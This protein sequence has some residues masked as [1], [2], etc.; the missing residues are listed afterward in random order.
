MNYE[1]CDDLSDRN[2][3]E[4]SG[5]SS[6][7]ISVQTGHRAAQLAAFLTIVSCLRQ[8]SGNGEKQSVSISVT[9]GGGDYKN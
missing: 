7:H 8:F 6:S 2:Y 5:A 3:Q 9:P 4:P 1:V